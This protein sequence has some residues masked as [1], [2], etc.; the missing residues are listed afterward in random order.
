[1][2]REREDS[3]ASE[4]TREPPAMVQLVAAVHEVSWFCDDSIVAWLGS[5]AFLGFWFFL[6][7][8]VWFFRGENLDSV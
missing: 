7:C 3:N 1:V 4:S 2:I 5:E 8:W 6:F